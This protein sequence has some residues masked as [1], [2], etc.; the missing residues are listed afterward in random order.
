MWYT[1]KREEIG[2]MAYTTRF[3][4]PI[5]TNLPSDVGKAVFKQ[6]LSTPKPN[7]IALEAEAKRLE[8]EMLKVRKLEEVKKTAGK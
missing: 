4:K 2:T 1:D 7:D 8:K 6:I 3:S 5:M